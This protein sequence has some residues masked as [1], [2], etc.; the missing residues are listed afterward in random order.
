MRARSVLTFVIVVLS[1]VG[2]NKSTRLIGSWAFSTP[3]ITGTATF[4]P[5]GKFQWEM[6][7][8]QVKGA[9]LEY[10]GKYRESGD[11][12]YL[13]YEDVQLRDLPADMKAQEP[14][15]LAKI[16]ETVKVGTEMKS[17]CIW[18]GTNSFTIN[19]GGK[20]MSFKKK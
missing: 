10:S 7:M 17:T 8:D 1:L 3:G 15:I 4:N 14:A 16:K 18:A 20:T 6:L 11:D 9:K 5:D 19:E 12:V 13:T 2:C